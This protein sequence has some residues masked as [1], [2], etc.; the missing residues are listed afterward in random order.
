MAKDEP[1]PRSR[2]EIARLVLDYLKTFLWPL[3]FLVVILGFRDEV[4]T[5]LRD[6]KIDAFGITIGGR[7]GDKV[8]EVKEDF[9]VEVTDLRRM[10]DQIKDSATATPEGK[11]LAEDASK[12]VTRIETNLNREIQQIQSMAPAADSQEPPQAGPSPAKAAQPTD[13]AAA[14]DWERAGFDALLTRDL[15]KANT[16]FDHA[17]DL[18]PDYHNV[19]EIRALLQGRRALLASGDEKAWKDLY[20]TLATDYTWG[21]TATTRAR[22]RITSA[23]GPEGGLLLKK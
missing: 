23:T 16:A 5:I 8:A 15:D 19:A 2:I 10:L 18:S 14:R 11:E 7:V 9:G 6:R 13:P 12:K 20:K 17:W 22:F 4:Q 21:M 3:A 1:D